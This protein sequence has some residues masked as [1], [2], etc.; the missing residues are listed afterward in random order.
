MSYRPLSLGSVEAYEVLKTSQGQSAHPSSAQLTLKRRSPRITH[1]IV[2][3]LQ[4]DLP[5][6]IAEPIHIRSPQV[7]S[8]VRRHLRRPRL[9]LLFQRLAL[10]NGYVCQSLQR[11]FGGEDNSVGFGETTE[12]LAF[13]ADDVARGREV[14]EASGEE[15]HT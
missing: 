12:S 15:V 1:Q 10:V 8:L 3:I 5:L 13:A 4:R 9:D 14:L 11:S 2:I 7:P 6:P